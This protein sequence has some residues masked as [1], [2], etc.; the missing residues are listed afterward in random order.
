MPEGESKWYVMH[1]RPRCEKKLAE[2]CA[3]ERIE[4]YLP[5]REETKIYQRRRV[6]VQKPLFPRYV[7]AAFGPEQ[8]VALLRSNNIVRLLDV[9]D[10]KRLL[11]ELAQVRS[12]LAVDPTLNACE[13][14][15]KGRRVRIEGGPFE[16]LEGI[17]QNVKGGTRVVLNVEMI[18]QAVAVE[19]DMELL[20][21]AE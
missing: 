21:P 8:R 9:V 6:T 7:F 14:F 13:A 20:E 5:L 3:A 19:V 2:H 1:V 15:E 16:G 11:D 17:V 10:Q 12:A 4:H 18:G